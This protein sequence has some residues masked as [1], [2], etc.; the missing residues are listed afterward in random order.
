MGMAGRETVAGAQERSR[1]TEDIL[2]EVRRLAKYFP[3]ISGV[4]FQRTVG[5]IKAVDDCSFFIR[6]GETL[7][8]VGES[9]SGKTTTGRCILQLDRPTAGEVLFDGQ[10]LARLTEAD[11]RRGRRRLPVVFQDSGSSINPR[12]TAWPRTG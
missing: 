3:V 9:G 2:L 5:I 10:D 1:N 12:L 6:K 7:G 4:L 8:L 11:L